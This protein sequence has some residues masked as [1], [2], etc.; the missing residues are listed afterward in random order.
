MKKAKET[1]N[2][3]KREISKKQQQAETTP[4]PQNIQQM[5]C[6][7][8]Y[9]YHRGIYDEFFFEKMAAEQNGQIPPEQ[10]T[11]EA[12]AQLLWRAQRDPSKFIGV[13]NSLNFYDYIKLKNP[14]N[15]FPNNCIHIGIA[16]STYRTQDNHQEDPTKKGRDIKR[17]HIMVILSEQTP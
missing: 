3:K 16:Y 9:G 17:A 14:S 5:P 4:V 2:R 15:M 10:L 7:V 6:R 1:T 11:P 8:E 12:M 13:Q